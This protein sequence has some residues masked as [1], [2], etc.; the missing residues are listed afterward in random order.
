MMM[1]NEHKST[2]RRHLICHVIQVRAGIF[3]CRLLD[4]ASANCHEYSGLQCLSVLHKTHAR[5]YLSI[6]TMGL[7]NTNTFTRQHTPPVYAS[8]TADDTVRDV[9]G[10]LPYLFSAVLPLMAAIKTYRRRRELILYV[11]PRPVQWE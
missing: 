2:T 9:L 11:N 6:I 1:P 8:T 7:M 10:E 3:V 4:A 5:L